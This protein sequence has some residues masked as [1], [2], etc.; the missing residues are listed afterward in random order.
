VLDTYNRSAV[1]IVRGVIKIKNK[2]SK[3]KDKRNILIKK[4]ELRS[5]CN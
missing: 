4:G 1:L 2:E 5:K 3:S